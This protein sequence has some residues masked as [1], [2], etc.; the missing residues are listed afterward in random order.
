MGHTPYGYRIENGVA[1]IDEA[2]A[3]KLRSLY[4][5]YLSGMSLT[6]AAAEAG[7]DTYHGTVKRLLMTRHYIGDIFYPAII[8]EEIYYKAQSELTTRA[9]V[10]GRINKATKP[11]STRPHTR[12]SIKDIVEPC[13]YSDPVGRAEYI[14]SLIESEEE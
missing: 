7:I 6:K 12:F 9:A 1:L 10:L 5:N 2:A 3:N 11:Q 4:K 14:Y 13:G 8:D